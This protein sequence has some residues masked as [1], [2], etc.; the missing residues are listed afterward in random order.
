MYNRNYLFAV[1]LTGLS[2]LSA[3]TSGQWE[4]NY[5]DVIDPSVSK[6]WRV[7]NIDVRVPRSLSVSEENSYAPDADIVWH[8]E[9]IGD[10]Y[11]QVDAIITKA[12]KNASNGLRGSR[13]VSLVIEVATFHALTDRTRY[14]LNDA[15]VHNISFAAQVFDARTGAKLS[16]P[17]QIQ[18]DLIAYTGYQAAAAEARGET[19][20]VRIVAH[21]SNVI[22]GWLG[23]GP[24]LRGTFSRNGR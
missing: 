18:A 24:D 11:Q 10:R 17:D 6:G 8:G 2:A 13:P 23:L 7:T 12:A 9:R 5:N 3:C 20:R 19:Q 1:L 22:S 15:G 4:T 16:A 21:V 14:T